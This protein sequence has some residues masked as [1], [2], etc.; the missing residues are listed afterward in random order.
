MN[1]EQ[2]A[3][4]CLAGGASPDDVA[5][6][7][8]IH[9][10]NSDTETK[11]IR[12]YHSSS[13]DRFILDP[14]DGLDCLWGEGDTILWAAGEPLLVCGPDGSGK[15]TIAQQ[16]AL[17]RMRGGVFFGYRVEQDEKRLVY[18][19]ADRPRQAKR[20][21]RRMVQDEDSDLL[22]DR[23]TVLSGSIQLGDIPEIASELDAGT[24]VIDTLGAVSPG[25][26]GTD[27]CGLAI[28]HTLQ[29]L[30]A[31]GVEVLLLHHTR[32][33]G[34]HWRGL[35]EVHGSRWITACLGSVLLL[36]GK[37]G[38]HK[39]FMRHVKQPASPAPH[40]EIHHDHRHGK[41]YAEIWQRQ[42]D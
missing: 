21:W 34:E 37:P 18:L 2:F 40:M 19:A 33:Q 12:S 6:L 1:R 15:T 22:R 11:P 27:A 30:V 3:E 17:A 42:D 20:S 24:V 13:G 7:W 28:Y 38:T 39:T 9:Q 5:Y 4:M 32:K 25:D 10:Q 8:G 35:Q 23:L 26:I 36:G 31:N 14:D 16:L 29:G 41:S